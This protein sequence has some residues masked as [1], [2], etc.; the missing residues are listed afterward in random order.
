MAAVTNEIIADLF[1]LG[2]HHKAIILYS[3]NHIL[4]IRSAISVYDLRRGS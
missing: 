2:L 3:K 1:I 4:L